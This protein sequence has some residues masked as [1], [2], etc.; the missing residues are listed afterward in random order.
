MVNEEL[1]KTLRLT[2]DGPLLL[3]D[4]G[5]MVMVAVRYKN[6]EP[7]FCVCT[8]HADVELT[9][10]LLKAVALLKELANGE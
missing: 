1:R 3:P 9:S 6:Q 8:G 10:P 7:G 2:D 4:C 5:D